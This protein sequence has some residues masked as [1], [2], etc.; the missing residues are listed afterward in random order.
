MF[1]P[2]SDWIL[3]RLDPPQKRSSVL[4]I[5]GDNNTSAVRTGTVIRTGTGKG[6][7]K[8]VIPIQVKPGARICFLRWHDEHRPGKVLKE[9]LNRHYS[10]ESS[11]DVMLIRESDVIFEF[12]GEVSVDVP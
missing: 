3:V 11:D 4:Q 5:A 2:L 9:T 7:S 10:L 1:Q 6:T 12:D 8:G